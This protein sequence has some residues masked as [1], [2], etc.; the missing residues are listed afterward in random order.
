[1]TP[2]QRFL[3]WCAAG[4]AVLVVTGYATFEQW[5]GFVGM[6]LSGGAH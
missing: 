1:M 5:S 4:S 6:L 2:W 3:A